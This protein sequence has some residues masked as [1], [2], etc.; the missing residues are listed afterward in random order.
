MRGYS[1]HTTIDK[2]TYDNT[3]TPHTLHHTHL[4]YPTRK[5]QHVLSL[6]QKLVEIPTIH[7]HSTICTQKP[8]KPLSPRAPAVALCIVGG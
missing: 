7:R 2:D 5:Q 6:A 3:L 8:T 4:K 1:I